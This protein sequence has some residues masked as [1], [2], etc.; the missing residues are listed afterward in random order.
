MRLEPSPN[1]DATSFFRGVYWHQMWELFPG[2]KTPGRSGVAEIMKWCQVPERLDGRHV[3]DIGA[4]NG[5]ASFECERRG[6]AKVVALS[7]EDPE[8]TGFYRLKEALASTRTNY[9]RGTIYD[10]DPR[11][12]GTFDVVLC[13]GV[14]YHL[15][16][17]LLGMD[18]L[19]RIAAG[20]LYLETYVIDNALVGERRQKIPLGSIDPR[21]AGARLM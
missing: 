2:V 15:R 9:V 8:I 21:L 16:Y 18:N 14:I 7:L 13:F 3:L 5:C 12:L 10:L 4:W 6:A 17:P 20:D 19:R 1:F 11:K